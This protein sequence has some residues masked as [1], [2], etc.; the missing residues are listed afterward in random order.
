MSASVIRLARK[1]AR[2]GGADAV[3]LAAQTVDAVEISDARSIPVQG[4]R[5]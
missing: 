3:A 2:Q 5:G 1:L 4:S